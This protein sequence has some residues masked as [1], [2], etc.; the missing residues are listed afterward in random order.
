MSRKTVEEIREKKGFI[1]DMDGVIYHGNE[2]IDGISRNHLQAIN[3]MSTGQEP[4]E[5]S[6]KF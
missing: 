3:W 6:E 2:L 5:M 1:C 4:A